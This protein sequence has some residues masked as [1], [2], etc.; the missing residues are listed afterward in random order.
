MRGK[1]AAVAKSADRGIRTAALVAGLLAAAV[2]RTG[3]AADASAPAAPAP[4]PSLV[5]TDKAPLGCCCISQD[6]AAGAKPACDYGL[7]EDKCRIAGH[8]LPKWGS[9]WT[10]GKCPPR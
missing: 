8:V 10:P 2:A 1:G 9:T 5:V 4:A 7:S 3:L 6:A